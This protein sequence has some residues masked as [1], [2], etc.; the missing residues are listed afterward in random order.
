MSHN[1]L[2]DDLVIA[3]EAAQA[4]ARSSRLEDGT[5]PLEHL[6]SGFDLHPQVMA[7]LI[8]DEV[9][10]HSGRVES[11]APLDVALTSMYVG[12]LL[13]GLFM[14]AVREGREIAAR[15]EAA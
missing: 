6:L 15:G 10:N 9:E 1:P 14:G 7:A 5:F 3:L 13:L 4:R 11:G 2:T 8:S 12:G